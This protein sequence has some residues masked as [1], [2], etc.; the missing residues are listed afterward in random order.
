[1]LRF[2]LWGVLIYCAGVLVAPWWAVAAL[3]GIGLGASLPR[4]QACAVAALV[5]LAGMILGPPPWIFYETFFF[6][7][8]YLKKMA[9][10]ASAPGGLLLAPLLAALPWPRARRVAIARVLLAGAVVAYLTLA[11]PLA[12]GAYGAL[13]AEPADK[14]YFFDGVMLLKAHHLMRAGHG[15]YE[16]NRLAFEKDQR[17]YEPGYPYQSLRPPYLFWAWSLLP[18]PGL[19]ATVAWLCTAWSMVAM[20]WARSSDEDPV[21]SLAA[22]LLLASWSIFF[23]TNLFMMFAD[24]WGCL[25][26]ISG[27]ALYRRGK[28]APASALLFA[29]CLVREFCGLPLV[30][31]LLLDARHRRKRALLWLGL[32][33]AAALLYGVH[34]HFLRSVL[35]MHSSSTAGARLQ[36]SATLMFATLRFGSV[37]ILGRDFLLPLLAAANVLCKERVVAFSALGLLLCWL[38]VGNPGFTQFYAMDFVPLIFWGAGIA[39]SL[40]RGHPPADAIE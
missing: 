39:L 32:L 13:N 16:A 20:W 10:D 18:S 1:M 34:E 4:A 30:V 37:Y 33:G 12:R 6:E 35:G 5:W 25:I 2:W 40:H 38:K 7:P 22:P 11:T 36:G 19:I 9:M 31:L 28:V 17:T 24:Y 23:L 29:A 8:S 15:Y 27:L 26:V 3:V 14:S 21:L